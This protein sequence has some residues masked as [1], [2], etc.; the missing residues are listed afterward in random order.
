VATSR[1][2]A[3]LEGTT[4]HDGDG[5]PAQSRDQSK[6]TSISTGCSAADHVPPESCR[7][8]TFQMLLAF[9]ALC[10]EVRRKE[11][12][13]E[14]QAKFESS[15]PVVAVDNQKQFDR[16]EVLQLFAQRALGVTH[17][18]GAAIALA[19]DNSMVLRAAAGTVRPD[20]GLCIDTESW[21]S[22][23]CLRTRQIVRCDDTEVDTLVN[24]EISRRLGAR[25]I[26]AVPLCVGHR[27]VGLLETFSRRPFAFHD[28]D[29]KNLNRLAGLLLR[30]LQSQEK[31]FLTQD[32][33]FG[34]T[35]FEVSRFPEGA[36]VAGIAPSKIDHADGAQANIPETMPLQEGSSC[37]GPTKILREPALELKQAASQ[38][39]SFV[40]AAAPSTQFLSANNQ[41]KNGT[42]LTGV[43]LLWASIVAMIAF[44][45]GVW[46]GLSSAHHRKMVIHTGPEAGASVDEALAP[47][48]TSARAPVNATNVHGVRPSSIGTRNQRL[49]VGGMSAFPQV[50]GIR[51]WSSSE[52]TVVVVNLENEVRYEMHCLTG[53][54]RIFIDLHDTRLAPDLAGKSIEANDQVVR[55]IRAAQPVVGV[56]RI[57]LETRIKPSF[58]MSLEPAPHQ[59]VVELLNNSA[60]PQA[61]VG[62]EP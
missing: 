15:V 10:E 36:Q 18:N 29:I 23:A 45:V 8:D 12:L 59:L 20:L 2:I 13:Q 6:I 19:E 14:H 30:T 28:R 1:S 24:R 32:M 61:W 47:F 31:D 17:A 52:S 38:I 25:S 55:R 3:S 50:T 16:N 44:A 57:V 58:S 34:A 21:V 4:P 56:T 9:S 41:A 46:W 51:H 60:D 5:A 40:A 42:R 35:L 54:N 11:E 26:V 53:P 43:W 62:C 39:T 33:Q 22:T 48:S 7:L 37:A 27:V 49:T